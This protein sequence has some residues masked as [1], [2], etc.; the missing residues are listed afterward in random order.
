MSPQLNAAKIEPVYKELFCLSSTFLI[1][2]F[3]FVRFVV[4]VSVVSVYRAL[5]VTNVFEDELELDVI[6]FMV[7]AILNN[8]QYT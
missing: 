1:F 4:T 3:T 2:D 5:P 7:D 6:I 8:M